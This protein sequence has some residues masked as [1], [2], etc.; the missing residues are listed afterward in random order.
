VPR[1]GRPIAAMTP[2]DVARRLMS[3]VR[4]IAP[5]APN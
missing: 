3:A 5:P 1:G 2:W 4:R